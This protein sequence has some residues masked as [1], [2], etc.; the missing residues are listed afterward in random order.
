MMPHGKLCQQQSVDGQDRKKRERE[1]ERNRHKGDQKWR[2][3]SNI[4]SKNQQI[5]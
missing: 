3:V 4:A 1:R 5:K 2:C